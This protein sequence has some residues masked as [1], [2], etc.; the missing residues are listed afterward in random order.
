VD[1]NGDASTLGDSLGF[2]WGLDLF[3]GGFYWEAHEAW[4]A[5]WMQAK[6]ASA[7]RFYLQ[8]LIQFAA[9]MLKSRRG[10]W[11]SFDSLYS[12]ASEKFSVAASR[13]G[14]EEIAW[15][16]VPAR[17]VLENYRTNRDVPKVVVSRRPSRTRAG[18]GDVPVRILREV[19]LDD[20]PTLFAH[21]QEPEGAA[22]AGVPSR[23]LEAFMAHWHRNIL[24]SDEVRK[25][26]IVE[27]GQCK[28]NIVSWAQDGE[29]L[30]GYWIGKAHWGQGVATRALREFLAHHELQRPLAAYVAKDN[31]GSIRVLQRCMFTIVEGKGESGHAG[32][33]LRLEL[34][35]DPKT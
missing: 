12:R 35:W 29:R 18:G 20:L 25:F 1:W 13:E 5:L 23:S 30:V 22:M 3:N 21:Q 15:L 17:A 4:E 31:L 8:G 9:A 34:V 32:E 10:Q 6:P 33:E 19:T 27:G 11:T 7:S 14:Y 24:A 28:G 2:R 16:V 26:A